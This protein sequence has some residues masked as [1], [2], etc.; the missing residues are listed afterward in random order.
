MRAG[1]GDKFPRC[2]LQVSLVRIATD[3]SQKYREL[4]KFRERYYDIPITV[5]PPAVII[6]L[7]LHRLSLHRQR[8]KSATTSS[9]LS[10][11]AKVTANGLCHSIVGICSTRSDIKDEAVSRK[12][13]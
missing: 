5:S 12:K 6:R 9:K 4:G 7:T 8:K 13:K 11:F 10:E 3:T 1:M 2:Q